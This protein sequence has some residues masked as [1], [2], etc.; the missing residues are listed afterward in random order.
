MGNNNIWEE[1]MAICKNNIS[2]VYYH[3]WIEP[4]QLFNLTETK[5]TLKC[6]SNFALDLVK[7]EFGQQIQNALSKAA[8]RAMQVHYIV[9][10]YPQTFHFSE[11]DPDQPGVTERF[12]FDTFPVTTSNRLA[13]TLMKEVGDFPGANIN[14]L[15]ICGGTEPEKKHLTFALLN[16][17]SEEHPSLNVVYRHVEQYISEIITDLKNH[18]HQNRDEHKKADFFVLAGIDLVTRSISA[19]DDLCSLLTNLLA[20]KKQIVIVADTISDYLRFDNEHLGNLL[21]AGTIVSISEPD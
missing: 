15:I 7:R 21:N 2:A 18:D 11:W 9:S 8:G 3:L 12:S 4:L 16:R 20:Q 19:Q 6:K 10:P 14:P 13:S 17:L 5:V 1:A